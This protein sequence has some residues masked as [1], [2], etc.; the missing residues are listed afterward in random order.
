MRRIIPAA[1]IASCV[2]AAAWGSPKNPKPDWVDGSSMEY[3]R[4]QY[5]V[6]VGSADDRAAAEDRARAEISRIFSS[7]VSVNTQLSETETNAARTGTKG[8]NTFSQSVSQSIETVSKKVLEGV[9]IPETWQDDATRV[10]YALAVLDRAKGLSAVNDK[11]ADFD[12]DIRQWYAQMVQATDK[13]PRV[14]AAMKLL[15]LFKARAELNGELRVLDPGGK[16]SPNPVDE[17]AVRTTAAKALAELDVAIDITGSKSREVETGVVKGLTGF[18]LQASA[19]APS[20]SVD[21]LATGEVETN[22]VEG[23]DSRW[24]FARSYVTV[25]LKDGRTNKVFLQFD[26]NEKSASADYNTAARR[27]LANLSKKVAQQVS[28]GINEYF[29]NQ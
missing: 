19:G 29:E 13:L 8:E 15:A 16:G 26:V 25:S 12:A 3:P 20:G 11:I 23:T 28:D 4:D 6:G 7:Q 2:A 22:P 21:I 24:K 5:L 27:S 14:K 10:Y 18:G 17:A 1:I 9:E